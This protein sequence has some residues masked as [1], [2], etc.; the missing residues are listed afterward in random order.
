MT[1]FILVCLFLLLFLDTHLIFGGD[2]RRLR[3]DY[4][5]LEQTVGKLEGRLVSDIAWVSQRIGKTLEHIAVLQ[6][7][8]LKEV[9]RNDE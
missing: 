9:K 6:E 1:D 4:E 2:I 3:R 8:K 7:K 5:R